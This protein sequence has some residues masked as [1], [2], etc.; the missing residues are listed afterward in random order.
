MEASAVI[1]PCGQRLHL[2]H[3]PIDLIIGADGDRQTAFTAATERFSTILKELA[4]ELPELRL[5]L[6]RDTPALMGDTAQR[7]DRA[8]RPAMTN[9]YV[10]RMAAVAGSVADTVLDAMKAATLSR[11]YVNNGG[12]IALYLT[13][14]QTF[15]L[16]MAGHDGS[17][18]GRIT[19]Q[20]DDPIRG[21]ATSGRH[22]RSFSLGIADS[23]TVLA[24]NAARA[25]VAATLIANAVD[26]PDHPAISRKPA[27]MLDDTSDLGDLPVVVGCGRLAEHHIIDALAR[28]RAKTD[29]FIDQNLISGAALFLQGHSETTCPAQLSIAQRTPHYA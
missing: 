15:T 3:G 8:V 18:F 12:D 17:D 10:T 24:E 29:A 23:V 13:K 26:I 2:Q 1:L 25:D 9:T 28:G 21:I 22:G 4:G 14:G 11:A 6:T 16:A 7:M 27:T 20:Y 19:I 5:P